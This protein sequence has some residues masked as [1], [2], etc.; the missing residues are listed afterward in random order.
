VKRKMVDQS[1]QTI[2]TRGDLSV[3]VAGSHQSIPDGVVVSIADD[4]RLSYSE[5]VIL[6][7]PFTADRFALFGQAC[8]E[9]WMEAHPGVKA[10]AIC[11]QPALFAGRYAEGERFFAPGYGP[12]DMAERQ[13]LAEEHL[14]AKKRPSAEQQPDKRPS[15]DADEPPVLPDNSRKI[16]RLQARLDRVREKLE[17]NAQASE[18]HSGHRTNP[19]NE[20]GGIRSRSPRQKRWLWERWDRLAQECADLIDQ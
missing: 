1:D 12:D 5:F 16:A 2:V 9:L 20:I 18:Q 13:R 7:P 14:S 6:S 8:L 4:G 10:V 3:L 15:A 11:Y 19:A 17:R